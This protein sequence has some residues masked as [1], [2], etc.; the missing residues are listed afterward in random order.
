MQPHCVVVAFRTTQNCSVYSSDE[1]GVSLQ[2]H[3][4]SLPSHSWALQLNGAGVGTGVG[5]GVA[6]AGVGDTGVGLGVAGVGLGVGAGVGLGV[7][8]GVAPGS[9]AH[10][11]P[12]VSVVLLD[13]R[14]HV[15][16]T[17]HWPPHV[18]LVAL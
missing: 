6:G 17:W 15:C 5:A 7:G 13:V 18:S 11:L 8:A 4:A 10:T 2:S 12:L 3:V 14:T 1:H 9:H 16:A